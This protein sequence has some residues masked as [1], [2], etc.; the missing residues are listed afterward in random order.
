MEAAPTA[1]CNWP[2]EEAS[3]RH[4]PPNVLRPLSDAPV[5]PSHRRTSARCRR[6]AERTSSLVDNEKSSQKPFRL[7][8]AELAKSHHQEP[9]RSINKSALE[10]NTPQL[11]WQETDRSSL[12]AMVASSPEW[13]LPSQRGIPAGSVAHGSPVSQQEAD[14]GPLISWPSRAK[15]QQTFCE[16]PYLSN[17][18]LLPPWRHPTHNRSASSREFSQASGPSTRPWQ[19]QSQNVSNELP[20]SPTVARRLLADTQKCP[21]SGASIPHKSLNTSASRPAFVDPRYS[22]HQTQ[23]H[24]EKKQDWDVVSGRLGDEDSGRLEVRPDSN[25]LGFSRGPGRSGGAFR[26]VTRSRPRDPGEGQEEFTVPAILAGKFGRDTD[27]LM[28]SGRTVLPS[29]VR[30]HEKEQVEIEQAVGPISALATSECSPLSANHGISSSHID[31]RLKGDGGVDEKQT[32]CRKNEKENDAKTLSEEAPSELT[33]RVTNSSAGTG[34][35]RTRP[36]QNHLHEGILPERSKRWKC[37]MKNTSKCKE[38]P[39]SK[40]LYRPRSQSLERED[41][42][43]VHRGGQ[44]I[45]SG[46]NKSKPRMKAGHT[47][48]R[49]KRGEWEMGKMKKEK[50][51]KALHRRGIEFV[52]GIMNVTGI[53]NGR[54][55]E[56]KVEMDRINK[57]ENA[58]QLRF[59]NAELGKMEGILQRNYVEQREHG[60]EGDSAERS[61]E[62]D[63]R[64]VSKREQ[65]GEKE[66]GKQMGQIQ[67]MITNGERE[68]AAEEWRT[69]GQASLRRRTRRYI[70]PGVDRRTSE[71]FKTQPIT[72]AERYHNQVM[73]E[74]SPEDIG[75]ENVDEKARLSVAAKRTL[76]K[77]MEKS[78]GSAGPSS[79]KL[80]S[81]NAAVE[82]RLRRRLQERAMTQLLPQDYSPAMH[83]D[84]P[85]AVYAEPI[86]P[87]LG[88]PFT[89]PDSLKTPLAPKRSNVQPGSDGPPDNSA[90][91][92][93]EK[94]AMFDRLAHGGLGAPVVVHTRHATAQQRRT[95]SRYQTQ[96]ITLEEVQQAS[97]S[98]RLSASSVKS[99]QKSTVGPGTTPQSHPIESAR[100]H[101]NSSS[102]MEGRK[103]RSTSPLEVTLQ[104]D[105]V[106]LPVMLQPFPVNGQ[107]EFVMETEHSDQQKETHVVPK[108]AGITGKLGEGHTLGLPCQS[109]TVQGMKAS[110]PKLHALDVKELRS[111]PEGVASPLSGYHLQVIANQKFVGAITPQGCEAKRATHTGLTGATP[112]GI[113]AIISAAPLGVAKC[114]TTYD[115]TTSSLP[116]PKT[117][118][119]ILNAP[120]STNAEMLLPFCT[121]APLCFILP[122]SASQNISSS[123]NA[124]VEQVITSSVPISVAL[125]TSAFLGLASTSTSCLDLISVSSA[126]AR[127]STGA[128]SFGIASATAF[129]VSSASTPTPLTLAST[130]SAAINLASTTS[131]ALNVASTASTPFSLTSTS[132]MPHSLVPIMSTP[133]ILASPSSVPFSLASTSSSNVAATASTM[134]GLTSSASDPLGLGSSTSS[135]LAF[136]S[137]TSSP[138]GL[139]SAA[140][141]SHQPA[142]TTPLARNN[143]V[144]FFPNSTSAPLG[145]NFTSSAFETSGNLCVQNMDPTD[146]HSHRPSSSA[147]GSVTHTSAFRP[148]QPS[149]PPWLQA[150]MPTSAIPED[151]KQNSLENVDSSK[152]TP[153]SRA[154]IE[155]SLYDK[156]PFALPVAPEQSTV[157]KSLATKSCAEV[158]ACPLSHA[159]LIP[160]SVDTTPSISPWLVSGL[161]PLP[162]QQSTS[163]SLA[164]PAVETW[165]LPWASPITHSQPWAVVTPT[166]VSKGDNIIKDIS[167]KGCA[168]SEESIAREMVT[169]DLDAAAERLYSRLYTSE[170]S[171]PATTRPSDTFVVPSSPRL[172]CSPARHR[173]AVRPAHKAPPSR[174]SLRDSSAPTVNNH[175]TEANN[176]GT[177]SH[178]CVPPAPAP[179][180]TFLDPSTRQGLTNGRPFFGDIPRDDLGPP[181]ISG[182]NILSGTR[183]RGE[184]Q[185]VSKRSGSTAVPYKKVMLIQVKGFEHI[186]SRL[187]EP[188][189]TSLNSGDCFVLITSRHCY[190]WL[191]RKASRLERTTAWELASTIQTRRDLGCRA[192]SVTVI[193]EEAGTEGG[194][195]KGFWS[196]LGGNAPYQ[197]A[198]GDVED[199]Q[200][201]RAIA[202]TNCIYRMLGDKLIPED[203]AW[204][205]VPQQAL[206]GDSDV[207][208][209]D[210]GSEVYVWHGQEIAPSARR[211]T[212]QLAKKLWNGTFDYSTCDINPLDPG[213]CNSRIPRKGRGRP[214]WAVFGRLSQHSE[215][216]LFKRKFVNWQEAAMSVGLLETLTMTV[217]AELQPY[218]AN[219][220]LLGRG[221]LSVHLVLWGV[222]VGRGRGVARARD[223]TTYELATLGVAAWHILDYD[224]SRLPRPS[225]GQFHE[226][227]T[228]VVK[229]RCLLM[230]TDGQGAGTEH[231]AYFF[232]QGR[233]GTL[234]E[235]MARAVLSSEL[236]AEPGPQ[237]VVTQGRE[238]A[239]LLQ[240]FQGG[241]IVHAG[242]RED[243]EAGTQAEWRLYCVRGELPLEASLLEVACHCSSLRSRASLLLL[244]VH[245]ALIYLWQGCKVAEPGR[246]V[247]RRAARCVKDLC[248]LE[249]GL[250][251]SS[252][253]TI[254]ECEEGAE[255]PT[256]WEALRR[257]DRKSY[258]CML[259]DP[260]K[261]NFSP[262]LF[263]LEVIDGTFVANEREYAARVPCDIS[264]MPFLQDE[265]YGA[266]QPA[267]FLVDNQQ[268][269]YLWQGWWPA[270]SSSQGPAGQQWLNTRRCAM[271]TTLNYCQEKCPE[272]PPKAYLVHAGLEPLTFTNIF[273][274]WEHRADISALTDQQVDTGC[275]IRPVEEEFQRMAEVSSPDGHGRLVLTARTDPSPWRQMEPCGRFGAS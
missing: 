76:F 54:E 131:A 158:S 40:L 66:H 68:R 35:D 56:N 205:R 258:D 240:L 37:E 14:G 251:N 1:G 123:A 185:L 235:R 31:D 52:K 2:E 19:M 264:A 75:Y 17:T 207:L 99:R 266:T 148:W 268:E 139:S 224:Y 81:R 142:L 178:N 32:V 177:K 79:P 263:C 53:V 95:S 255:A 60:K 111:S 256:F 154:T 30:K 269:I 55:K 109:H 160:T 96:P 176:P 71:R 50:G 244:N 90:L 105:R 192:G 199:A 80:R 157:P 39:G 212:F 227:D 200:Y 29:Q 189:A 28:R 261:F 103:E 33:A 168:V 89:S 126:T 167:D 91:T 67:D 125:T 134:P 144:P 215:T 70:T 64:C 51:D 198:R 124:K 237:V 45:Q 38:E 49:E 133:V 146:T 229:W 164:S 162:L 72:L 42:M 171:S 179:K 209:F 88:P 173:L 44:E 259:L 155:S 116:K 98:E 77:E 118:A 114:S 24:T 201:E 175:N 190:L 260:G 196:H 122:N 208:V 191:G 194:R 21:P 41:V 73:E 165:S 62:W 69:G 187:V 4:I 138:L 254:D 195:N 27:R 238:P 184:G 104:D 87:D 13:I 137:T 101:T 217:P 174:S 233:H 180:P 228:Y 112:L 8:K 140:S 222:D 202:E 119:V 232:W 211:V 166:S 151:V 107:H 253:V 82:R 223:G 3:W 110:S 7:G 249:A 22:R 128:A 239:C 93:A 234:T 20:G 94:M 226:G 86:S 46:D 83:S 16:D 149:L 230:P 130:T 117:S 242:K 11:A 127:V 12:D 218:N 97:G 220:M 267:F 23:L 159:T 243:E 214:D 213:A 9:Q 231:C 141:V 129:P 181:P 273:P 102:Q 92:L 203:A 153:L 59:S 204:G 247:G 257:K 132:C 143:S 108:A 47:P 61:K 262:R 43:L 10:N 270:G 36:P 271:Q 246:D 219:Q 236:E 5:F 145:V 163:V 170:E 136:V 241:M 18:S 172:D 15:Q 147:L 150:P 265:L 135:P 186:Q 206:L 26:P 252:C 183:S 63:I 121:T 250:H 225:V 161:A 74:T 156:A 216:V 115:V 193:D 65:M 57:S 152:A 106:E 248:P 210:F 275:Q 58:E 78:T 197:A 6:H 85:P 245:R 188:R 182:P 120:P 100:L 221:E 169:T 48:E 274:S 34:Q 25:L 272:K 84:S 113:A